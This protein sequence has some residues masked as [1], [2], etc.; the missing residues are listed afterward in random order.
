MHSFR[1]QCP[2]IG[3]IISQTFTRRFSRVFNDIQNLQRIEFL[4]CSIKLR[5]INCH[6]CVSPNRISKYNENGKHFSRIIEFFVQANS[7]SKM[8]I[9][10]RYY[11]SLKFII[12]KNHS[13]NITKAS[14]FLARNSTLDVFH[15]HVF[16]HS[17][18]F[19]PECRDNLCIRNE[20]AF[21]C[22]PPRSLTRD[23][24]V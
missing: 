8:R 1:K 24:S 3:K 17:F 16:Q 9:C 22:T 12:F 19:S 21:N 4:V 5:L 15:F 6:S 23:H 10:N 18:Y 13:N 14:G 20:I 2:L 11:M 7:R